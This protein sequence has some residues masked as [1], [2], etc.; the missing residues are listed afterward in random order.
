MQYL[1][2][3]H[4]G[5]DKILRNHFLARLWWSGQFR[6]LIKN[7]YEAQ[8]RR[9]AGSFSSLCEFFQVGSADPSFLWWWDILALLSSFA[10]YSITIYSDFALAERKNG[11]PLGLALTFQLVFGAVLLLDSIATKHKLRLSVSEG[12]TALFTN[13]ST[14]PRGFT[15]WL[16]IDFLPGIPLDT[17]LTLIVVIVEAGDRS[18][19]AQA[20]VI[21]SNV[22]L[23]ALG[24]I[25]YAM[26]PDYISVNNPVS[27]VPKTYY[28]F[29]FKASTLV[30]GTY[31]WLIITHFI[32]CTRNA[33]RHLH[34]K[35]NSYM[36]GLY[37][38][39]ITLC[40]VGYSDSP[41]TSVLDKV[42]ACFTFLIGLLINSFFVGALT[43]TMQ[44]G[45]ARYVFLYFFFPF[46]S[47]SLL[48]AE[49]MLLTLSAC[50][51]SEMPDFLLE[52]I[53]ALQLFSMD[54]EYDS[55]FSDVASKMPQQLSAT[56]ELVVKQRHI[57]SIPFF[58]TLSYPCQ[59][60][61]ASTMKTVTCTAQHTMIVNGNQ[62]DAVFYLACGY[63]VQVKSVLQ[64]DAREH[65]E[66]SE[67]EDS[68]STATPTG[69]PGSP[70][71]PGF[72]Q[73]PQNAEKNL[74]YLKAGA[75]FGSESLNCEIP[76]SVKTLT[77]CVFYKV[78]LES[79]QNLIHMFPC[80][81]DEPLGDGSG[82]L[83]SLATG[84]TPAAFVYEEYLNPRYGATIENSSENYFG[85][86]LA[87]DS[88]GQGNGGDSKEKSDKV[89]KME[90]SP[91]KRQGPR[92]ERTP[93]F[94]RGVNGVPQ[95]P[96]GGSLIVRERSRS[97]LLGTQPVRNTETRRVKNP[98]PLR[99]H[100]IKALLDC[101]A[102]LGILKKQ[103]M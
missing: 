96:R 19:L 37:W 43:V 79:L 53:L 66:T 26:S 61:L 38:T 99:V 25:F 87:D 72:S 12:F 46:I 27:K 97:L 83:G 4:E 58:S 63:A 13:P 56:I 18:V 15:K 31:W 11:F 51:S 49:H 82:T 41:D 35:P 40:A 88:C 8:K 17:V 47:H 28:M 45:N 92:P 89:E 94:R 55:I 42:L 62:M 36:D 24:K 103:R 9:D 32:A 6:P 81:K 78:D 85:D 70:G 77:C 67:G 29:V 101:K 64:T 16:L 74:R 90:P 34:D 48:R 84:S 102:F 65:L 5:D 33:M 10:L 95:S 50:A 98:T 7:D 22:R 60:F 80:F 1:F 86:E 23:L 14:V 59:L 93:S 71:S 76:Y 75:S 57:L 39:V 30:K 20:A 68:A 54:S 69:S 2:A 52:Q 73:A 3:E 44:R 21:V 100:S 91:D